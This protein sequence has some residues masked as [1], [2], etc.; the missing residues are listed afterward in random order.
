LFT[1]GKAEEVLKKKKELSQKLHKTVKAMSN[2]AAKNIQGLKPAVQAKIQKQISFFKHMLKQIAPW[3]KTGF[4]PKNKILSLW[5]TTARSISK[6]KVGK[7][8][9]FGRRWIITRLL[10]GYIIGTPC[11]KLGADAD[12]SIADEV[13]I[14]FMETFGEIPQAVV[15]DRGADSPKNEKFLNA[16]GVEEVCIFKKGT[17]KMNVS[18]PVLEM[19]RRERSLNESSIANI[20]HQKY[21]FTKP[22]ARSSDSCVLKGHTAILGFNVNNLF[23]DISQAWGMKLEIT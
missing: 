10:G 21:N 13:I 18:E 2:L 16:V 4:H 20:K 17:E 11:E 23:R 1:R 9:E 22:R 19:A 12:T 5:E 14:N 7:S 8:C 15:Y 3:L 6:G